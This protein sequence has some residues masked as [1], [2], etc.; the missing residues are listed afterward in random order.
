[1][2]SAIQK[3][4][5][6]TQVKVVS[7]PFYCKMNGCDKRYK[8]L[9][10]LKYHARINHEH[11]DFEVYVKGIDLDQDRDSTLHGQNSFE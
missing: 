9:N 3:E 1:M 7:K 10:G 6:Q 4:L 2:D 11:L 5:K 8:N